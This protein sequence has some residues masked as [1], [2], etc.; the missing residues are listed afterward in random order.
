MKII[1]R[2]RLGALLLAIPTLIALSLVKTEAESD[3]PIPQVTFHIDLIKTTVGD[4]VKSSM[5]FDYTPFA[6]AVT[7]SFPSNLSARAGND[8]GS[9]A[10]VSGDG[11]AMF[12]KYLHSHGKTLSKPT[13]TTLS[14][15]PASI[16]IK[17]AIQGPIGGVV[18]GGFTYTN[19]RITQISI[20]PKVEQDGSISYTL[21]L[22]LTGGQKQP[23]MTMVSEETIKSEQTVKSGEVFALGGLANAQYTAA[24]GVPL[25]TDGLTS[26]GGFGAADPKTP[27]LFVFVTANT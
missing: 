4:V 24:A 15:V 21:S 20:T 18:G 10:T 1:N 22:D 16:S 8:E 14:G 3:I 27:V 26:D 25:L 7:G 2:S 12:L 5:P 23:G 9:L 6:P 13:I 17:E 11:A 19:S